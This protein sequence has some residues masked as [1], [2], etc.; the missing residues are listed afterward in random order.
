MGPHRSRFLELPS[1]IR[2]MIYER[3]PRTVKHHRVNFNTEKCDIEGWSLVFITRSVPMSILATC[4][5]INSEARAVVS[6]L[7][8]SFVSTGTPKML[9]VR[10]RKYGAVEMIND[11]AILLTP[12]EGVRAK[13][14]SEVVKNK[15]F[16]PSNRTSADTRSTIHAR[17]ALGSGFG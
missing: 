8:V 10:E 4:R 13:A 15:Y 7:A 2:L 3:L 16:Y 5:S 17:I 12:L 11:L 1:E 9:C 6:N 14:S